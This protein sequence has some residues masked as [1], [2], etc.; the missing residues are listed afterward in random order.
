MT[1]VQTVYTFF[2]QFVLKCFWVLMV[3]GGLSW[4]KAE[5]APKAQQ[6][7]TMASPASAPVGSLTVELGKS[8]LL[9]LT[10]NI[11]EIF[12]ANPDIADVQLNTPGVAYVFGKK[13]GV[14]NLIVTNE[15]G[16]I[17]KN[18]DV[19]VTHNLSELSQT[20]KTHF[21]EENV[22]FFSVP[23]GLVM[24]GTVHS[25]LM[26][27]NI[28]EVSKKYLGPKEA[29]INNLSLSSPMQVLLRVKVAEVSR[30][31]L[32]QLQFNWTS[33]LDGPGHFATG[34]LTGRNPLQTATNALPGRFLRDTSSS[35]PANSIG[36]VFSD[37]VSTFA[38]LLDALDQEGL[39]S[40]LAEPN[41]IAVS[42][43]TAS[44][45]AGGEFPY[46]VPQNQNITI[47]F[48]Q[49]GVSLAF[50]ATILSHNLINLR[51]RPEVSQ[52]DSSN[53]LNLLLNTTSQ[54]TITVPSIKTRRTET[55]VEL[56][57]GQ[58][59]A[60]AGLIQSNMISNLAGLPGLADI[61][62]LGALFRSTKFQKNQ[63][64]L[65]I[66][67]TPYIIKPTDTPASLKS[68]LDS[69]RF[70]SNLEMLFLQR[71]NRVKNKN[72]FEERF[73]DAR[74]VRFSGAAGFRVY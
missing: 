64:E 25:P 13:T 42:G 40:I 71:L 36:V 41:L 6:A 30:T 17:I 5:A 65:V 18:L 33:F 2:S 7:V 51:V 10:K 14:T 23:S 74:P 35:N 38:T 47:E 69:L 16:K 57:S 59:L 22:Q 66:I 48:K 20:I 63:S 29:L 27:K 45:L 26:M 56:G 37:N 46:P 15:S 24:Q 68:P 3:S 54:T 72:A 70:A 62:I 19:R 55:T 28:E 60:I 8:H 11:A 44:F 53:S 58:S 43:Q 12:V 1:P 67:V 49:F 61:P 39:A 31:V 52:L 34:I 50:T 21:P 32:N 4:Q 73:A 9:K